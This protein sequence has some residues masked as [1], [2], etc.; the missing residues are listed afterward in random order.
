MTSPEPTIFFVP[1][2]C[3]LAS[4]FDGARKQLEGLGYDVYSR[5]LPS[6]ER[7]DASWTDDRDACLEI[8]QP[9]MD[10]GKEIVVIAHSYGGVPGTAVCQN[11]SLNERA[12]VGKIGGVRAIIF[13]AALPAIQ[14]GWSCL[15]TCGGQWAPY[16]VPPPDKPVGIPISREYQEK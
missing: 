9:M 14:H 5:T 1:G 11:H 16:L 13:V 3:H 8:M 12:A 15:Q 6:T 4:S 10:E 7:A 2:A